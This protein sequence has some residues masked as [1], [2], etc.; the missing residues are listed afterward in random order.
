MF[1]IF[2]CVFYSLEHVARCTKKFKVVYLRTFK[3]EW[4]RRNVQC[5]YILPK[6]Y[7]SGTF[8]R[9][10]RINLSHNINESKPSNNNPLSCLHENNIGMLNNKKELRSKDIQL[11]YLTQMMKSSQES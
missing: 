7:G 1:F 8:N 10:K 3:T 2:L 5:H 11:M 4:V 9:F 6:T